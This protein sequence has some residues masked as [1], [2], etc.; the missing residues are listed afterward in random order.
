MSAEE[1]TELRDLVAQTLESNGVLGKIR[2][3]SYQQLYAVFI[4]FKQC[5]SFQIMNFRS[6]FLTFCSNLSVNLKETNIAMS[7]RHESVKTLQSICKA[8][9]RSAVSPMYP[10]AMFIRLCLYGFYFESCIIAH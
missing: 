2:V 5:L 3:R 1:D 7:L 10:Y 6:D 8:V 4:F 9:L